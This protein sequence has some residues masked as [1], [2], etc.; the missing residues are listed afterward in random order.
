M[1][2]AVLTIVVAFCDKWGLASD[3]SLSMGVGLYSVPREIHR[4]VSD[5]LVPL[6]IVDWGLNAATQTCQILSE[7]PLCWHETCMCQ[8]DGR[9]DRLVLILKQRFNVVGFSKRVNFI[10]ASLRRLFLGDRLRID[11]QLHL[12]RTY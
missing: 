1:H 10:Q 2:W 6:V 9:A 8:G 3:G 11:M 4:V 5:H 12:C 7:H